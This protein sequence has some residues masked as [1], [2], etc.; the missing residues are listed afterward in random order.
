MIYF[1][2]G[3]PGSGKS[4]HVARDIMT[5]LRK[6]DKNNVICNFPINLNVV[7]GRNKKK[8]RGNFV[9]KDNSKLTHEYL[10]NYALKN[11]IMGVEG[12]TLVVIDECQ[13]IFNPREFNRSD[14]LDWIKFFTIHRHL[15]YNF[16]LISQFDRLVDR[17]I[18]A[19]FEYE[20]T[21]RKVNNYKIG[22]FLPFPT[23]IAIERWYGVNEKMSVSFFTYRKRH[24]KLYQ[25]YRTFEDIEMIFPNIKLDISDKVEVIENYTL[26][27]DME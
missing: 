10:I 7:G 22:F 13:V 26:L 3:T 21:H 16:I 18:R 23:F 17:Q 11:H 15:G 25:S 4:L 27:E 9:Y 24:S 20:I 12:Q 8:L 14:R 19:L 2:S 1:Y 6:K 5:K